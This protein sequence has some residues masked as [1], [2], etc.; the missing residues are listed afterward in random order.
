MIINFAT[1]NP[2]KL[3]EVSE[4]FAGIGIEVVQLDDEYPEIQTDNLEEVVR[5]GLDW[6]WE[7]HKVPLMIDDSGLFI[8]AFDA[9]PGVYSA[10]VFKAL[11]CEGVLKLMEGIDVRRAE[12]RC[13]AGYIDGNGQVIVTGTSK[14]RIT[15]ELLGTGGFGYDPIFVPQEQ[16]K[17]FAQMSVE[18]KN[19]MSHRG[20]AFGLL[21]DKLRE[22]G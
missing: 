9:F 20:K 12:F 16:E 5:W 10:F 8:E 18:E 1:G 11:G 19:S 15:L 13:C 4:K 14:G 17:T 22:L 7:R 21:T 2:G 6:L 3:N